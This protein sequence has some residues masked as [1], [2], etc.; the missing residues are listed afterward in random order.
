MLAIENP[1]WNSKPERAAALVIGDSIVQ[2]VRLNRALIV[3]FPG[4]TVT[5]ITEKITPVLD[6]QPQLDR[7]VGTNNT[8]RQQS[9]LLKQDFTQLF[10]Q[11]L[12]S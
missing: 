3:S 2:N 8:P 9:E 1:R 7:V 11:L 6:C 12:H 5:D 4:A 10:N